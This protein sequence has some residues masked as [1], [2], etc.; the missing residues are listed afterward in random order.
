MIL[1][2]N[3]LIDEDGRRKDVTT[4]EENLDKDDVFGLKKRECTL[5]QQDAV[6]EEEDSIKDCEGLKQRRKVRTFVSELDKDKDQEKNQENNIKPQQ[7]SMDPKD[8]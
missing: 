8:V 3:T 4:E 2:S 7:S 6:E 5:M 1:Y